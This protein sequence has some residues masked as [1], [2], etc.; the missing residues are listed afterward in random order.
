MR[1][2]LKK[3]ILKAQHNEI[4]EYI[5]YSKLAAKVKNKKNSAVL[6]RIAR[7]EL[8]HYK[9]WLRHSKTEVKPKKI[10]ICFYFWIARILGV[11]FG[12][13]LMERGEEQAQINYKALLKHIPGAT[14]VLEDEEKHEQELITLI[15]EEK[16]NYI[17]SIVL[18][19]NDAL[20]ELTGALAGLSLAFQNTH[21]IALAGLITG[22]AASLSMA[23]SE[24]LSHKSEGAHDKAFT[25]ALYTGIAYIVTVA[26]LVLPYFVIPVI[27]P[28]IGVPSYIICLAVTLVFAL[29]VIFFFNFY[30]SVVRDFSFKKRFL[31]MAALSFGVAGLSFLIGYVIRLTLGVDI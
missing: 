29:G 16:L 25:S 1:P 30:I 7:D 8:K 14:Q 6:A 9:F 15:N 24:Y 20:V 11:T 22:I 31:E 18:G 28:P 5:I 12:I 19:L 4:T 26:L 13:K 21:F 10:K 23:S 27:L 17:G 2:E 3:E